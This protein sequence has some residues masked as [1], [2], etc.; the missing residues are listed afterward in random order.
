MSQPGPTRG[1]G[2]DQASFTS[3]GGVP[4]E[5]VIITAELT[6]RPSRPPDYEG[7]SR[8]L[9]SLMEEMVTSPNGILQKLAE[10]AL[11]LC[12]AQSAG[13]SLLKSDGKHF[14]WPA[15]TG[16]WA[17]HVGGGTPREY[18]PCGT[19]LD[20]N[21]AQLM[22]HVER[23]FTY[24]A[25]V[26]PW[27]EEVL[28]IPFYVAGEA[29]G[30]IWVI[31]HDES[32]R[33]DRE[34]ERLMSSLGKFASTAYQML[35][36]LD[37]LKVQLAERK[38]SEQELRRRTE[39]L[40]ALFENAT[41]GLHWVGPDGMIRWANPAELEMLGYT[42]EEYEGHHIAEFYAD[43]EV[44]GDVLARLA[45]GEKLK[46]YEAQLRCQDGS[47]RD[48][49]IDSSALWDQ[50]CFVHTQCFTR[51][52]TVRKR[53]EEELRRF[54]VDLENRVLERTAELRSTLVEREKLQEQLLQ[55]QKMESIGM[56]AGG[57]AHEF[58]N[59]LNIIMAYTMLIR[60]K[61]R[62]KEVSEASDVIKETVERAAAMVQELLSTARKTEASFQQIN[63]NAMLGDLK[64]L[65][66]ETF[67]K[68]I[69]IAL[70][71]DPEIPSLVS[72]PNQIHQVLLNMCVNAR[73]SMPDGGKLLL[74][75]SI[76]AGAEL[77]QRFD[78][79]QN[80]LYVRIGVAD[81]GTGIDD[82]TKKRIF[83]PF[84]TTKA[85]GQGTGLGLSVA[86]G[87]VRNHSGFI[88]VKSE[89]GQ[90]TTFS[91]YLP[92]A[93][94]KPE[95]FREE[96]K[97]DGTRQRAA[98]SGAMVLFVD[99]EEYQVRLM[100]KLLEDE[101]YRVLIA[102]DGTEAVE[103][104]RRHKEE[105]AVT[106]LD[107]GLPK[108]NGWEALRKM[109]QIDPKLSVLFA[110]GFVPPEIEAKIRNAQPASI[111]GKPYEPTEVLEKISAAI[112]KPQVNDESGV[113]GGRINNTSRCFN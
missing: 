93:K 51:D 10:T 92:I 95:I 105:I 39:E 12:R 63:I 108:L 59:L 67:P 76:V 23:C 88:D 44:V 68:I 35:S 85:L 75:T 5:S 60:Y 112:R 29:V 48:V 53:I 24:F 52:I 66:S 7:E 73:D 43:Q 30:T 28:L 19:V 45:R 64:S 13:I 32:R 42:K 77:R 81:T 86:Y 62:Q 11:T 50:R 18:G 71:L 82:D 26:T 46:G 111:I 80:D 55:A 17:S 36:S 54:N 34:D 96:Q 79:A 103:L 70:D 83:E 22:S 91:I 41:I 107:F 98:G 57:I 78:E 58:N 74:E 99:D 8:A 21:A 15:I 72:D 37:A 6:R 25:P 20:R 9:A 38:Q 110:T 65:L 49:L 2:N 101:G 31:A 94:D 1:E 89:P 27:I 40:T 3:G 14:Y 104:H 16:Q 84:F 47:I 69:D 113:A 97:L 100:R 61:A 4:L 90:G 106:V 109:K 56:L 102:R 33:F 87:I